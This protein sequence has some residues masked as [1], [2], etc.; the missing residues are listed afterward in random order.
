MFAA[1]IMQI[2]LT[3][4]R[5]LFRSYPYTFTTDEA[6]NFKKSF[7]FIHIDHSTD[8]DGRLISTRTTTTFSMDYS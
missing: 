4:H 1:V 6:T 5:I 2:D 7:Q 3:D 8:A